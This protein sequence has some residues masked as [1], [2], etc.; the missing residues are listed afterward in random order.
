MADIIVAKTVTGSNALNDLMHECNKSHGCILISQQ[1]EWS[2]HTIQI[3]HGIPSTTK[4]ITM[5]DIIVAPSHSLQSNVPND[6]M[7]EC[8]KNHGHNLPTKFNGLPPYFKSTMAFQATKSRSIKYDCKMPKNS[9]TK[10][11]ST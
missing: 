4:F 10:Q 1:N 8:N 7:H 11:C 3:Q 2:S 6:L 9:L 5:A